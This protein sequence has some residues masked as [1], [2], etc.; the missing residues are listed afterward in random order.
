MR[1]LCKGE[2]V[3][4]HDVQTVLGQPREPR[5]SVALLETKDEL[6]TGGVGCFELIQPKLETRRLVAKRE[7]QLGLD[8]VRAPELRAFAENEH[9]ALAR[10]HPIF[11]RRGEHRRSSSTSMSMTT[12]ACSSGVGRGL[13]W[14]EATKA[15]SPPSEEENLN[16]KLVVLV[17]ADALDARAVHPYEEPAF[18]VYQLL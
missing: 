10:S 12:S 13:T 2:D 14:S 7:P 3:E 18:D 16:R 1:R 11:E 5:D 17:P 8:V 6:V 4:E 15:F 9:S